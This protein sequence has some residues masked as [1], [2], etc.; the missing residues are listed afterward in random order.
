MRHA[1]GRVTTVLAGVGTSDLIVS[2]RPP[3][4]LKSFESWRAAKEAQTLEDGTSARITPDRAAR[5][6]RMRAQHCAWPIVPVN[7]DTLAAYIDAARPRIT[8]AVQA[9]L[10]QGG[11]A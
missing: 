6:H 1:S 3:D 9:R 2:K 8:A 5:L 4:A 7:D 10:G 11:A